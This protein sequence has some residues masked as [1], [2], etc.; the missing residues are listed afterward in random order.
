MT[1]KTR[2]DTCHGTGSITRLRPIGSQ[3]LPTRVECHDCQ[4]TGKVD[5]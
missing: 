1:Q 4:G 2:C 5:K 3:S